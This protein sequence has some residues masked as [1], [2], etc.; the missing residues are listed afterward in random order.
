MRDILHRF[1]IEKQTQN[2]QRLTFLIFGAQQTEG[3]AGDTYWYMPNK[4]S[5]LQVVQCLTCK[6]DFNLRKAFLLSVQESGSTDSWQ[7]IDA[8]PFSSAVIPKQRDIRRA[9]LPE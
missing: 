3:T 1:L 9:K 4:S 5:Y 7:T 8:V 6:L 2:F